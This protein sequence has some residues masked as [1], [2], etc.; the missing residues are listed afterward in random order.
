[1]H[2]LHSLPRNPDGEW[3]EM[4]DTSTGLPYYYNTASKETVWERPENATIIP[5][6]AV[7][8]RHSSLFTKI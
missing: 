1:M 3:W 6:Q 8:V 4:E 7:Q 5:L 2:V